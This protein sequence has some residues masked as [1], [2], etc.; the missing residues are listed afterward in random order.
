M[1]PNINSRVILSVN[2]ILGYLSL[3][4]NINLN[5][6]YSFLFVPEII[7]RLNT[8]DKINSKSF[9]P[10]KLHLNVIPNS[11]SKF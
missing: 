3:N 11:I 7:N 6:E 10:Y 2:I 4:Q 9:N 8:H 5:F 1:L